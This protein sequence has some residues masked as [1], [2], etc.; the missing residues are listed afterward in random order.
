M[1]GKGALI[2]V[3]GFI[4]SFSSFQIRMSKNVLAT[5]D[6]FNN[7]Y[8]A[9]VIHQN[10]LTAMNLAVNKVWDLKINSDVFTM[11]ANSC[12]SRSEI[13]TI[14]LD[15]VKVKVK[16]WGHIYSD[17]QDDAILLADSI[18]AYFTNSTPISKYFWFTDDEQGVYWITG[19][20]VWGPVHTNG[21]IKTSGSPVFHNKVTAQMGI[22]PSPL[23][24]TAEF[25]GGWEIGVANEIPTDMSYITDQAN[26]DNGAAPV[27]TKCKYDL[28]VTFDFQSDGSAIRTVQGNPPDT[29]MISALTPNG[30]IS[31][32]A[33]IRVK[34]TF[35]GELTMYTS[36][37]IWIDD[38]LVYADDP[39]TNPSS[40]DV[41]G[42]VANNNV[43]VTD[44]AANNAD[45]N[46]QACM[47]AV[48]GSF[49]AEHYSSRPISGNL[50]MT[51][52]IVQKI[53]GPVGTF[54]Y[55]SIVSGFSKRYKF[56]SRLSTISPPNYP[57]V[58]SL[59]L[60][61]WWE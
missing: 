8:I 9:T 42:L 55:G 18:T 22:D 51:G 26:L 47:M 20:S 43:Y 53:R 2:I 14:G 56:D 31:S 24:S 3:F 57:F 29:V 5:S 45:C 61:S 25:L 60:V 16:S 41:L 36:G 50:N 39:L 34:G 58:K 33:D 17:E 52:S 28:P 49:T 23:S 46:I 59:S 6:N 40:D 13:S 10:S 7:N 27:N 1:L 44:N 15:T 35:N 12:S 21:T 30:A 4:M 11:V 37:N 38:D 19:D 48:Q 54:S 32:T